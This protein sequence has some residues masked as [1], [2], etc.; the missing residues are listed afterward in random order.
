MILFYITSPSRAVARRIAQR[1][2]KKRLIACANVLP[3]VDSMYWWKGKIEKTEE[4]ALIAKTTPAKARAVEN[5]VRE[6][7][8]YTVPCIIKIVAKANA[9]YEKWLRGE[10]NGSYGKNR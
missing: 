10:L 4:W 6:A 9:D 1:L 2:L 3:I 5:E 7:H 8:P